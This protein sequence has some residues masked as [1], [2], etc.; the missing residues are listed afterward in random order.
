[1]SPATTALITA[2]QFFDLPEPTDGSKQELVR[3]EVVT[4]PNPGF[5]HGEVQLQVGFLIKSFLK[6]NPIG[7]AVTESGTVTERKPDTVRGP[8]VSF[9]S[10]ARLPL[11][12]RVQKY[13]TEVPDLCAEV[14]SPSNSL[15]KLKDKAKEYLFAGVRAVW[16]VDPEDR[17]VTIVTE[18]LES[19]VLEAGATLDGGDVLPGFSCKVAEFFE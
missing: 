15:R 6:A 4:M 8:D 7:R 17:T 10:A 3:G 5:E 13:H 9:Y 16:I 11:G 2:E 14:V 18:P 1:M 19:R 12:Q